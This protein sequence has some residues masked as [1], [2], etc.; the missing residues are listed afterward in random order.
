MTTTRISYP[1]AI[2]QEESHKTLEVNSKV[3]A[4]G[5]LSPFLP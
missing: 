1:L 2:P 4:E 3:L 5:T